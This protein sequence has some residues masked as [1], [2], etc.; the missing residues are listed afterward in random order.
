MTDEAQP[1]SLSADQVPEPARSARWVDHLKWAVAV[2]D[3]D[4]SDL[5][6]VA[7]LLSYSIRHEG[8]TPKQCHFA[9]KIMDRLIAMWRENRLRCQNI[10]QD[11]IRQQSN[12]ESDGLENV[13]PAGRA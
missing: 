5:A 3:R 8:L 6:F 10:H 2:M 7:S 1:F 12:D 4:D 11:E 13:A 9:R